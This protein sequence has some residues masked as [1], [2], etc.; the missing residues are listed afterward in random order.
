MQTQGRQGRPRPGRRR[1]RR[2]GHRRRAPRVRSPHRLRRHRAIGAAGHRHG[3]PARGDV[4]RHPPP[5]THPRAHARDRRRRRRVRVREPVRGAG[6]AD[7]RRRNAAAGARR[8]RPARRPAVASHRRETGRHLPRPDVAS[9]RSTTPRTPSKR[10]STTAPQSKPT[11]CSSRSAAVHR[12]A[13]S[14]SRKRASPS[15]IATTSKS[16][17][18]L[19]TANPKIWAA[20]D[21]IGGLQLAHLG[22]AEGGRAVENALGHDVMPMDR[23]V[24]PSCIYTHP[25]IAMV[26]LNPETAKAA[27]HRA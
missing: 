7:H 13:A 5:R 15:T 27:G 11:S 10:T 18:Y 26:G 17:T 24:V 16:T 8:R 20:G 25:E 3:A 1:R 14:V 6:L 21:C 4:Q 22:S 2:G 19:R 9:N 23:T 12:P